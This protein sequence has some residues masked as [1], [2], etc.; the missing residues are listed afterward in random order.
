[1]P[2]MPIAIERETK[3]NVAYV[4]YHADDPEPSGRTIGY[5]DYQG[6]IS[7]TRCSARIQS[8]EASVRACGLLSS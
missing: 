6:V 8:V 1:M 2:R 7:T 3:Y 4:R 5:A